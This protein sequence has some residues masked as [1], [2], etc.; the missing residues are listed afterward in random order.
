M[1]RGSMPL[2]VMHHNSSQCGRSGSQK[3][4]VKTARRAPLCVLVGHLDFRDVRNFDYLD[5]TNGQGTIVHSSFR[6][7]YS[8]IFPFPDKIVLYALC[9]SCDI[10]DDP[11]KSNTLLEHSMTLI[12]LNI[13]ETCLI[14]MKLEKTYCL[15]NYIVFRRN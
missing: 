7:V 14:Q 3:M 5:A 9:L 6:L 1:H 13:F 15:F 2:E 10:Q 11:F 4:L 12:R 8:F